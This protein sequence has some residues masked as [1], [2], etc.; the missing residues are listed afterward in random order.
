MRDLVDRRHVEDAG[1][2]DEDI[3]PAILSFDSGNTGGNGIHIGNIHRHRHTANSLG[4]L[5]GIILVYISRH[6]HGAG[7]RVGLA[8][9]APNAP[10]A[11]CHKSNLSSK[12]RHDG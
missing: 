1:I 11:T 2:I 3:N 10:C 8:Y 9:G 7:G 4:S 6:D 5:A 12:L